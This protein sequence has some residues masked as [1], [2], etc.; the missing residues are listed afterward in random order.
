MHPHAQP[1][2][3]LRYLH[4]LLLPLPQMSQ[5]L[6]LL[7]K[8]RQRRSHLRYKSLSK[9]L[10]SAR[11]QLAF[12]EKRRLLFHLPHQFQHRLR[13]PLSPLLPLQLLF[14]MNHH[15]LQSPH[16]QP[17]QLFH[18]SSKMQLRARPIL[19]CSLQLFLRK[20]KLILRFQLLL[21]APLCPL[22]RRQLRLL[23]KYLPLKLSHMWLLHRLL[24]RLLINQFSLLKLQVKRRRQSH[25]LPLLL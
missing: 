17:L 23:L 3:P 25:L 10:L 8:S 14:Q 6:P 9:Q 11:P 12:S 2:C 5:L 18:S 21:Y 16:L 1:L 15:R 13:L 4:L 22:P 20:L 24:S 7:P 19:S